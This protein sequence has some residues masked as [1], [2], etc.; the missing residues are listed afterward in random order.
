MESLKIKHEKSVFSCFK[1]NE[2]ED[3]D[4][5]FFNRFV[6]DDDAVFY[7]W[8]HRLVVLLYG[9]SSLIYGYFSTFRYNNNNIGYETFKPYSDAFELIFLFDL[10]V[11]FFKNH[12]T[13]H[14]EH[15]VTDLVTFN[16]TYQKYIEGDFIWDFIPL[17]PL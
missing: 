6:F 5:E 13:I 4:E 15:E 12:H 2:R 9:S 8:Y 16:I 3:E 1:P 7:L 17:I 14:Q 11:N 10:I